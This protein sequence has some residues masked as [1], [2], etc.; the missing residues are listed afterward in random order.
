MFLRSIRL[1][2]RGELPDRYPFTVPAVATLDTIALRT[3]VVFFA[4]ENASGKS[5]LL[6]GVAAGVH[7]IPVRAEDA[8]TAESLHHAEGLAARLRF[9]WTV[10]TR[11][12][13][14]LRAEDFFEY[15]KGLVAAMRDLAAQA[16]DAER[17][18]E[19]YG[20][21]LARGSALG[22]R[23]ALEGRYGDDP[24][25]RS[26]GES[27]LQFFRARFTGPGLYLLDE[28]DTALSV[29]SAIGL[30]ALLKEMVAEGAQ[31]LIATHSPILLAYPG[32]TILSFDRTP[33]AEV[34]Y[35]DVEQ[36]SL[37]RAF[38]DHPDAFLRRL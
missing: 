15:K 35:D 18:F 9:S 4:G 29:Q 7:S 25:A 23:R 10:K 17:R 14:F 38:L 6:E 8:L 24:N 36:V 16:D 5:T 19:G 1:E 22:Q 27:F 31:F 28:P 13:F 3:P 11:Q 37:L 34:A 20:R 32:A 30:V 26:H 12:G 2:R 33:I 21:A